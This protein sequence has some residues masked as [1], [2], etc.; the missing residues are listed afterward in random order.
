MICGVNHITLAVRRLA[1]AVDFYLGLGLDLRM[2]SPRSAYLS[3]GDLWL[4][5]LRDPD[6]RPARGYT[7][8]AFSVPAEHFASLTARLAHLPRWQ[9]NSSPGPSL[10]LTDPDG[11]R[12]ELHSGT[13][14]DRLS[15][16]RGRPDIA[17]PPF[18]E[19]P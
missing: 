5:L 15:A 16:L 17:F 7:H 3:A 14:D 4:C 13:L 2:R 1:P 9:E 18:P 12:I 8:I 19:P 11:H 6:H 10:Y